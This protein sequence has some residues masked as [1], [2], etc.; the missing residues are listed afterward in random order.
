[1]IGAFTGLLWP[2]IYKIR[3]GGGPPPAGYTW[4]YDLSAASGNG[5]LNL[6][7]FG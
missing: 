6:L 3:T 5:M 7:M 1:M 2:A 4:S